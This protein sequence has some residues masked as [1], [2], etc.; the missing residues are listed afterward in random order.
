MVISVATRNRFVVLSFSTTQQQT[1]SDEISYIVSWKRCLNLKAELIVSHVHTYTLLFQ[2]FLSH[3]HF[4][5][6]FSM[7]VSKYGESQICWNFFNFFFR[8][9]LQFS[10]SQWNGDDR[11]TCYMQNH[12]IDLLSTWFGAKLGRLLFSCSHPVVSV[13]GSLPTIFVPPRVLVFLI[14]NFPQK[15]SFFLCNFDYF[16]ILK[17]FSKIFLNF[18]IKFW[19]NKIKPWCQIANIIS[20]G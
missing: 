2:N 9:F 18:Y 8:V 1:K 4:C 11:K 14:K 20:L 13:N 15:K 12:L 6:N 5:W 19:L 16:F 10:R 7:Q 3:T 17:K